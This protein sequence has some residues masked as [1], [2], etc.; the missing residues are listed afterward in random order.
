MIGDLNNYYIVHF[1]LK[2]SNRYLIWFTDINDGFV[3]E[4]EKVL[5]FDNITKL[6][7][8]V[9]TQNIDIH[10]DISCFN[11]DFIMD[12]MNKK[13]NS[14]SILDL[15][16]ILSDIAKSAQVEFCGDDVIY[17]SE[18]EK[19]LL[20]CN[21]DVINQSLYEPIWSNEEI[22]SIKK[23]INVGYNILCKILFDY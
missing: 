5:S 1:I 8:Y 7:Q 20:G 15:W 9:K 22:D 6:M 16:N 4:N 14:K 12:E 11:I 2:K 23:V 18:Y 17:N 10:T 19:L 21:L 13:I 3:T